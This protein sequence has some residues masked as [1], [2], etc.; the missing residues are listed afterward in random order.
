MAHKE[1]SWLYYGWH[2]GC[3]L[4]SQGLGLAAAAAETGPVAAPGGPAAAARRPP[5]TMDAPNP[6]LE[7]RVC[8]RTF[9]SKAC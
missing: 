5:G 7:V 4:T 2:C 3:G 6:A 8:W 1:N 9:S